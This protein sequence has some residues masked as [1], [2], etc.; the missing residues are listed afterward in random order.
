M[1][2]QTAAPCTD[3]QTTKMSGLGPEWIKAE[4]LKSQGVKQHLNCQCSIA[5][6]IIVHDAT[7]P[8]RLLHNSCQLSTRSFSTK[9]DQRLD[10]CR[11]WHA[12]LAWC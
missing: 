6:A 9:S 12:G 7:G 5:I 8:G 11:F 1:P 2:C 4:A 10:I 3:S